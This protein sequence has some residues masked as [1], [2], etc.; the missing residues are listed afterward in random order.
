MSVNGKC[1]RCRVFDIVKDSLCSSCVM[2]D[3]GPFFGLEEKYYEVMRNNF[4]ELQ[5]NL[6]SGSPDMHICMRLVLE[7]TNKIL[8]TRL[9]RIE[10][11]EGNIIDNYDEIDR[12]HCK[13]CGKIRTSVMGCRVDYCRGTSTSYCY[14][15]SSQDH[16]VLYDCLYRIKD[17]GNPAESSIDIQTVGQILERM[18]KIGV[19]DFDIRGFSPIINRVGRE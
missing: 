6:A 8:Y 2:V 4:R 14:V 5:Q 18:H 12:L 16:P 1:L 15:G 10:D 17:H 7:A 19:E 13:Q 11:M 3:Q 9:V